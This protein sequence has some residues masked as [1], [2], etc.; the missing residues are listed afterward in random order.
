MTGTSEVL[1]LVSLHAQAAWSSCHSKG[2]TSGDIV[3][4]EAV[5]E[6]I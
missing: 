5:N 3:D 1:A 6:V 4:L 2:A